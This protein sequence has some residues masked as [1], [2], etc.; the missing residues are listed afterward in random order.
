ML[1]KQFGA[2]DIDLHTAE[3]G[4]SNGLVIVIEDKKE[5]IVARNIF[6]SI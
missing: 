1:N 3:P 6:G 5:I 4:L 2:G